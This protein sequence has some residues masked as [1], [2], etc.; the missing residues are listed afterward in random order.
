[1][2]PIDFHACRFVNKGS[3][4]PHLT[5]KLTVSQITMAVLITIGKR[6]FHGVHLLQLVVLLG[7]LGGF[8][9]LTLGEMVK[10]FSGATMISRTFTKDHANLHPD[11]VFCSYDG[12]SPDAASVSY[13]ETM[14][15]ERYTQMAQPAKVESLLQLN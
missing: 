7:C 2:D 9:W 10:Y 6:Q 8:V 12:F 15:K 14:D 13:L 11:L 5:L 3:F 1:M 4:Q